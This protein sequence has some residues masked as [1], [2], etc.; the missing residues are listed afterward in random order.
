MK[1]RRV[2]VIAALAILVTVLGVVFDL[3]PDGLLPEPY[4]RLPDDRRVPIAVLGD[5]DSQ[6][7]Q[8]TIWYAPDRPRGG[9]HHDIAL[10]WTEVLDRIR[11]DQVDLG[12]VGVCGGRLRI[13]KLLEWFGCERRAPRK[14]D[15][16]FNFAFGGA[17]CRD[18]HEGPF[19]QVPRLLALMRRDAARWERGVV[20]I[21]M[22]TNDLA[23]ADTL[24]ALAADPAD[25]EVCRRMESCT[26]MIERAIRAVRAEHPRT[27]IVVVG[28]FDNSDFPPY[29]DKWQDPVALANIRAGIDHYNAG[30]RRIADADPRLA[31]FDDCAWFRPLWGGR[32]PAG[33]PAYRVVEIGAKIRITF[34]CGDE[35]TNAL[36]ADAHAGVA[37]NALW[38]QSLTRFLAEELRVPV[39]PVADAE[40][41]RF[42]TELYPKWR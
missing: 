16:Q 8:D 38:C 27:A 35:P 41:E 37:W 10:Q 20:V 9:V 11:H 3:L 12:D 17:R 7:F 23:H 21:R 29:F 14:R 36:L 33:K 1:R 2:L 22:G 4:S 30:L 26:A 15:N 19:R 28:L 34:T 25:R 32:D 40:V 6:G 24:D 13:V 31:F 5:S 42:L 18:L 39:E